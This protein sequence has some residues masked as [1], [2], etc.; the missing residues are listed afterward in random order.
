MP[1]AATPVQEATNK[2]AQSICS[3]LTGKRR[4]DRA[5]I[6]G[7]LVRLAFHDA[8]TFDGST[9]GADGCVDLNS[10][11]N[12]GLAPVIDSLASVVQLVS[13]TLSRADVWALAATVAIE[14]AGGPQLSFSH[15]RV[16]SQSCAGHG[17]RLPSAE[18][19]HA[20]IRS[21]FVDRL[22]F[23]ESAVAALMG[24]HVLGRATSKNTGYNGAW[25][26]QADRF[27]NAY[28][29]D[30]LLIPWRKVNN[31]V[32]EGSARTQWD[33]PGNTMMLNTDVE[34]AF[35]TSRGC[36]RAGGR[37]GGRGGGCPRAVHGFSDAVTE[38]S[39]NQAAFFQAF[40]PAFQSL[41][42]LGS[43]SLV[44]AFPDCSTPGPL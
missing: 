44:C 22:G 19:N 37:G 32:F 9:G 17:S 16:D 18:G 24:A 27:T 4:A 35:D 40:A 11:H 38:F 21:I 20:N 14:A 41:V 6:L 42:A 33:G 36:D 23:S 5:D 28:F 2:V 12:R 26:Q 43:D 29:R 3:Q 30:L 39:L 15:G 31:P 7:G 25:V 13:G 34:I 1:A 8:G 10:G